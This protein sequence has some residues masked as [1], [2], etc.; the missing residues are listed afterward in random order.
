MHIFTLTTTIFSSDKPTPTASPTTTTLLTSTSLS[1]TTAPNPGCSLCHPNF[2]LVLHL[3]VICPYLISTL[4]LVS[5]YQHRAKGNS[6]NHSLI[7]QYADDKFLSLFKLCLLLAHPTRLSR[8]W[9]MTVITTSL[10]QQRAPHLNLSAL[11]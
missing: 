4:L 11:T 6:V 9:M 1:T 2:R 10:H 8:D 7:N 3:L 5:L